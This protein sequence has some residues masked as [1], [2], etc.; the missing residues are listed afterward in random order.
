MIIYVDIDGTIC[1]TSGMDYEYAIPFRSRIEQINKL[2]D[3]GHE[4]IYW[5]ARGSGTGRDHYD[6]TK[7]QLEKW[8]VKY[9]KFMVGKPVYDL[10]ICDKSINKI[11]EKLTEWLDKT[12]RN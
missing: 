9:T 7:R 2:F 12:K 5:T 6:M 3:E 8:G 11:D 10:F 4:I 1:E